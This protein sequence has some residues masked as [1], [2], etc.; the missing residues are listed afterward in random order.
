MTYRVLIMEDDRD[1]IGQWEQAFSDAGITAIKAGNRSE[2]EAILN[3]EHFDALVTDIFV[4]SAGRID[5]GQ[6]GI[7]LIGHVRNPNLGLTPE[8]ARSMPIVAVT[9]TPAATMPYASEAP[10]FDPLEF[11]ASKVDETLRKPFPPEQLVA[12][13]VELIE[14][15]A[16]DLAHSPT[17]LS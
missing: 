14:R 13:V 12:L 5:A 9:A 10:T 11:T 4:T 3:S 1:L 16:W 17:A 7:L 8:W 2:A 15:R 6:G